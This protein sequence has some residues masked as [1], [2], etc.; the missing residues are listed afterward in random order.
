MVDDANKPE[1]PPATHDSLTRGE[2]PVPASSDFSIEQM[3]PDSRPSIVL[4]DSDQPVW[5]GWDV[6]ALALVTLAS[7][8][9]LSVVGIG[10]AK[11]LKAFRGVSLADLTRDPR[12]VIPVQVLAYLTLLLCMSWI[13][14]RHRDGSFWD[15][16]HWNW[17]R[18]NRYTPLIGGAVLALAIQFASA[19][20]PI[21]KQLPI[22]KFFKDTGSAYL[23]AVF[24]V[25]IAPL[26][27]E[28]FFRGF[29]YPVL[30]RRIGVAFG[31]ALT[32]FLF[33]L[34][35]QSQLGYAWAPLLLLFVVG[36]VLTGVRAYTGSVARGFLIHVGY[37]ATLF[38]LLWL[39]TGHFHHME[40][41]AAAVFMLNR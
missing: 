22:E 4:R 10:L 35:H 31:T 12:I 38:L 20:L 30:A 11:H 13:V 8:F 33:A 32:A 26:M 2:L 5:T 1:P 9:A 19:L 23:M 21:P 15:L 41:A 36:L 18:T 25:M 34:I 7:M 24:G 6:V 27:E 39:Q 3:P 37:N 17:P 28:L 29:L 16:V 14:H 40:R